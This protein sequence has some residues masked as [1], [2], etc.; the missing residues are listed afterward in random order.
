LYIG[1]DVAQELVTSGKVI[2]EL[3][4]SGAVESAA[5]AGG[6]VAG[7]YLGIKGAAELKKAIKEKDTMAAIEGSGSISAGGA[8]LINSATRLAAQAAAGGIGGPLAAMV[9]K[10][11][12][13]ATAGTALGVVY[14]ATEIAGGSKSIYDG[15]KTNDRKKIMSGMLDSAIGV[16]AIGASIAGSLPLSLSLAAAYLFRMTFIDGDKIQ[17]A[18]RRLG[19]HEPS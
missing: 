1:S 18:F 17:S 16:G 2:K 7:V 9:A 11:A 14:G 3:G 13:I 6:A 5:Q 4:L 15:F 19:Q 12:V 8:A 10:S